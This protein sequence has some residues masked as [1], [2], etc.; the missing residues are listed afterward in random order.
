M[1]REDPKAEAGLTIGQIA[2]R[3]SGLA[4]EPTVLTER[5]RHWAKLGFFTAIDREGEGTGKH[6]LYG[7][8]ALYDA[9]ILVALASSGQHPGDQRWLAD[10]VSIAR[11]ELVKW[12][13]ARLK[14]RTGPLFLDIL[15]VPPGKKI[16]AIRK[17]AADINAA[18]ARAK[19]ELPAAYQRDSF[20]ALTITIDLARIFETVW[21]A[22]AAE[23]DDASPR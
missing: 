6:V 7:E 2:K 23:S 11:L 19:R 14:G 12:K 18:L 17:S 3:V 20:A 16:T 4:G 5:C 22:G 15:F 8:A 13:Q 10:V 1:K 21:T 9:A